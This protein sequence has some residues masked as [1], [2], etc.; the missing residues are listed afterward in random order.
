MNLSKLYEWNFK[1]K[2]KA[3]NNNGYK[4]FDKNKKC[5]NAHK[6]IHLFLSFAGTER[7]MG[8]NTN[9]KRSFFWLDLPF[10]F[11][12]DIKTHSRDFVRNAHIFTRKSTKTHTSK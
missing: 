9:K 4:E 10:L 1:S 11:W 12:F 7:T 3:N 6:Y 2:Q 8:N 5:S